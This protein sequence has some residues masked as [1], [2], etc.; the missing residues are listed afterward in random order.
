M[1]SIN[2]SSMRSDNVQSDD[3]ESARRNAIVVATPEQP[4]LMLKEV[5]YQKMYGRCLIMPSHSVNLVSSLSSR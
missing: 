1:R 2:A 5:V 3:L 4:G